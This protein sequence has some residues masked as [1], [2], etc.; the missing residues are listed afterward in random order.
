MAPLLKKIAPTLLALGA[1]MM[2]AASVFAQF[3]PPKVEGAWVRSAVPGQQGTG[4]FMKLTANEPMQLVRVSTPVAG[5]AELHEMKMEGDVMRM[6]AIGKLE[7]PAGRTVELKSGGYHLM[8]MDWK[9][10]L[11]QGST[12]PI[13]LFLRDSKGVESKL[14]LSVPVRVAA[15]ASGAAPP[16]DAHKH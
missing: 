16:A 1:A 13:S 15:P 7:L 2:V 11:V 12:V 3:L 4:A 14:E 9:R 10:P 6:R 8:L 5:V